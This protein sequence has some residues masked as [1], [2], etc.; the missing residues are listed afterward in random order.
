MRHRA[1]RAKLASSIAPKTVTR[2]NPRLLTKIKKTAT[3]AKGKKRHKHMRHHPR[4]LFHGT[5][6]HGASCG[7]PPAPN[8]TMVIAGCINEEH[9]FFAMACTSLSIASV[10][11]MFSVFVMKKESK[12]SALHPMWRQWPEATPLPLRVIHPNRSSPDF[13]LSRH[14]PASFVAAHTALQNAE[15]RRALSCYLMLYAH[16]GVCLDAGVAP[17]H[18]LTKAFDHRPT[19]P[20][21][22]VW[23]AV[24]NA[25]HDG[26]LPHV[27]ASPQRNPLLLELAERLASH[28]AECN[29]KAGWA[30][31]DAW[32]VIQRR[33]ALDG[34]S[35]SAPVPGQYV[36]NGSE[37]MLWEER[38]EAPPTTA[39]A[40]SRH[41]AAVA[42]D[43]GCVVMG[44]G[45]APIFALPRHPR[46]SRYSR[47]MLAA[48]RGEAFRLGGM[49]SRKT[50]GDATPQA[51]A[52]ASVRQYILAP[53]TRVGWDVKMYADVS[54]ASGRH[55]EARQLLRAAGFP[56]RATRVR[57]HVAGNQTTSWLSTIAWLH[58]IHHGSRHQGTG[59]SAVAHQSGEAADAAAVGFDL[60]LLRADAIFKREIPLYGWLADTRAPSRVLAPWYVGH[61]FGRTYENHSAR[62]A[63]FDIPRGH[64]A[65]TPHPPPAPRVR[66]GYAHLMVPAVCDAFLFIRA[67]DLPAVVDALKLM[68]GVRDYLTHS[69]IHFLPWYSRA[70]VATMFKMPPH[71][72]NPAKEWNPLYTLCAHPPSNS[73]SVQPAQFAAARPCVCALALWPIARCSGA[74]P[75]APSRR[76][77]PQ[78]ESTNK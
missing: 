44:V 53:L 25:A 38:C 10:L 70:P 73:P 48:V 49:T 62:Y 60:L 45:A 28:V 31:A 68:R 13:F 77:S 23:Y 54:C 52:F 11:S 14:L 57:M 65:Y 72:S 56:P 67:A 6:I 41:G 40:A 58:T 47:L 46:Y 18:S 61:V 43:G 21:M 75:H 1:E 26:I 32:R 66:H 42:P 33:Y 7:W 50:T 27:L 29:A 22:F 35:P 20:G 76:A 37:L 39:A 55:A 36:A 63:P 24:L 8:V 34:G 17:A 51:R 12:L 71:D 74:L 16:G 5:Q 78:A 59:A 4:A 64:V 2:R 69:S 19:V 15:D 3:S 30:A 9:L